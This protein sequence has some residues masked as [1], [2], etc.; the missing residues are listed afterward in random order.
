M[1]KSKDVQSRADRPVKALDLR[2]TAV[3]QGIRPALL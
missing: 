2:L 1:D 3:E